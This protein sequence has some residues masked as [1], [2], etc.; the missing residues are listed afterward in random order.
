MRGQLRPL[1]ALRSGPKPAQFSKERPE[2]LTGSHLL[3]PASA[4]SH[5]TGDFRG[6]VIGAAGTRHFEPDGVDFL[7]SATV[8][9][10][11]DVCTTVAGCA[12]GAIGRAPARPRW[13]DQIS[14][15][16]ENQLYPYSEHSCAHRHSHDFGKLF[17]DQARQ[18][19]EDPE[20]CCYEYHPPGRSKT[21]RTAVGRSIFPADGIG[22]T[23]NPAA[24]EGEPAARRA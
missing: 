2:L 9:F 18:V 11:G 10:D 7:G 17:G 24:G 6:P 15:P 4:K 20:L 16:A 12:S 14:T 22:R 8:P 5:S 1:A 21:V 19:T 23:S 13:C 3:S